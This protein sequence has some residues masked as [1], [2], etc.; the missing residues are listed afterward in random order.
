MGLNKTW[1][2]M[3]CP[4]NAGAFG[5]VAPV[6]LRFGLPWCVLLAVAACKPIPKKHPTVSQLFFHFSFAV[7]LP[8]ISDYM[9]ISGDTTPCTLLLT[10]ADTLKMHW[11]SWWDRGSHTCA[12]WWHVCVPACVNKQPQGMVLWLSGHT[13]CSQRSHSTR[14]SHGRLQRTPAEGSLR[15]PQEKAPFFNIEN[16]RLAPW[17]G[18]HAWFIY[19]LQM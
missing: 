4:Q 7:V 14:G 12:W 8:H 3:A 16:T 11:S 6:D 9:A 15:F 13:A 19:T 18:M 17:S 5:L 2:E 1:V 10:Q